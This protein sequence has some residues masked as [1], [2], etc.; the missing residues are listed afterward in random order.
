MWLRKYKDFSKQQTR[1]FGFQSEHE[2]DVVGL[3]NSCM[4]QS[5]ADAHY[6]VLQ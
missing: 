3:D 5:R 2:I 4:Y 6:F 1:M